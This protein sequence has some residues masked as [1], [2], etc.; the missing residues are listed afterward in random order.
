MLDLVLSFDQRLN[1]IV[2]CFGFWLRM[3]NLLILRT[4]RHRYRDSD[5]WF[6]ILT[7]LNLARTGLTFCTSDLGAL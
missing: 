4:G 3:D 1:T 7:T 5:T 6:E 2:L